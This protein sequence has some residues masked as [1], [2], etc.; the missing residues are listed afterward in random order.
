MATQINETRDIQ[1]HKIPGYMPDDIPLVEGVDMRSMDEIVEENKK[2][3]AEILARW[4]EE[5]DE[6]A[7]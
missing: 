4:S 2:R 5:D 7:E 1:V 6:A 3:A